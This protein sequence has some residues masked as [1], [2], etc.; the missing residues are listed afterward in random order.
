[1]NARTSRQWTPLHYAS[2]GQVD[3]TM[4]WSPNFFMNNRKTDLSMAVLLIMNKADINARESESEEGSGRKPLEL[5]QN[6]EHKLGLRATAAV[7]HAEGARMARGHSTQ[8]ACTFWDNLCRASSFCRKSLDAANDHSQSGD[9]SPN[10]NTSTNT[11]NTT[12][13]QESL[14]QNASTV[15]VLQTTQKYPHPVITHEAIEVV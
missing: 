8:Y 10:P 6:A 9:A 11:G 15:S 5:V 12:E 2:R 14:E 1:M 13:G 4:S 7:V 3:Q